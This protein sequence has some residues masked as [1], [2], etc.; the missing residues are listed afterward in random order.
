MS[1]RLKHLILFFYGIL[2]LSY[3]S[4]YVIPHGGDTWGMAYEVSTIIDY[5]EITWYVTPLSLFGW[6][7]F[8][9][10][11]GELVLLSQI[12]LVTGIL[13]PEMVYLSSALFGI[14]GIYTVFLMS[15]Q[16]FGDDIALLTSFFF[17]NM[18][19]VI[20]ATWNTIS[21]RGLF[22][23]LYPIA[24]FLL[25]RIRSTRGKGVGIKYLLLAILTISINLSIHRIALIFMA[26]VLFPFLFSTLIHFFSDSRRLSFPSKKLNLAI[27]FIAVAI[28]ILQLSDFFFLSLSE[29][30][31]SRHSLEFFSGENAISNLLNLAVDYGIY[32]GP[33]SIL[34]P[35][36][37]LGL[38]LLPRR[39][40]A[41]T[42][43]L[44]IT[45]MAIVFIRDIKYFLYFLPRG[46]ICFYFIS[47]LHR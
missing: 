1:T 21:T 19:W 36:G 24:L 15:R 9:Y 14:M 33:A 32:Y 4:G 29:S 22:V 35:F 34:A 45:L 11:S 27:L 6:F 47:H 26:V 31:L 38:I 30:Q 42:T 40:F 20:H 41:T 23:M 17:L 16:I 7:P 25:L 37:L 12:T 39:T 10:P 43:L 2:A 3:R 18:T 13:I 44:L 28:F 5:G 8:S 46:F